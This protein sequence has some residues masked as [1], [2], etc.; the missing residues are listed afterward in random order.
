MHITIDETT[1]AMLQEVAILVGEP[2]VNAVGIGI[3]QQE[4]TRILNLARQQGVTSHEAHASRQQT[5]QQPQRQVQHQPAPQRRPNPGVP[6][7]QPGNTVAQAQGFADSLRKQAGTQNFNTFENNLGPDVGRTTQ[8]QQA[9]TPP[10]QNQEQVQ[11]NFQ[12][13]GSNNPIRRVK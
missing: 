3:I 5:P 9:P 7:P 2:S 11:S 1:Y 4:C 13:P 8:M 6:I 10:P 12:Y